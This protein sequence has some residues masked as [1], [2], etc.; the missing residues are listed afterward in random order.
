MNGA[1]LLST[2]RATLMRWTKR[3]AALFRHDSLF[4]YATIAA[5][6]ALIFLIARL[7]QDFFAPGGIPR[8]S[9]DMVGGPARSER[10]QPDD[11]GPRDSSV[12]TEPPAPG[13][14]AGQPPAPND[15]S[16][17]VIEPGRSLE[18]LDL[19]PAQRDS[20]GTLPTEKEGSSP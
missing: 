2:C 17:P 10:V 18:G 6:L 11:A 5:V 7:A 4:R 13:S 9:E 8:T 20:F 1:T 14:T 16:P 12:T 19:T 3:V 15:A